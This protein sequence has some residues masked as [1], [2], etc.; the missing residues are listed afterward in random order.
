MKILGQIARAR[1]HVIID[2][3]PKKQEQKENHKT[4]EFLNK[5]NGSW[6]DI[7]RSLK[8]PGR[9]WVLNIQ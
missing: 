2:T 9:L 7:Q 5:R 3:W 6:S 4:N 1:T 8:Y